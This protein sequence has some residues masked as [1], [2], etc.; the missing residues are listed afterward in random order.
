MVLNYQANLL[1]DFKKLMDGAKELLTDIDCVPIFSTI[2]TINILIYQQGG[3]R[4]LK[5]E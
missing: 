1:F 4:Y 5:Y 3:T 2:P